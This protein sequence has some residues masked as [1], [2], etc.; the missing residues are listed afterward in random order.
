MT[1]MKKETMKTGICPLTKEPG[2][3][4]AEKKK[5]TGIPEPL[6]AKYENIAGILT[7]Q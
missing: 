7:I 2:D 1:S 4:V 5:V 3:T 6:K